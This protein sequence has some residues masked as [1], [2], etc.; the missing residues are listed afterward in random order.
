MKVLVVF[1][2]GIKI[3]LLL[4]MLLWRKDQ[5]QNHLLP[6]FNFRYWILDVSKVHASGSNAWDT[7]VHDASEEYKHR[8]VN[9]ETCGHV[10]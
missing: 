5:K 10:F 9:Q 6:F 1:L 3:V 4:N 7:A 2:F 8:M